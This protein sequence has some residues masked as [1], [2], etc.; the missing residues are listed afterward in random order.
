[1]KV[2]RIED[3]LDIAWAAR[4]KGYVFNPGFRGEA[5]LG[6]SSVS[7]Q[8]VKKMNEKYK[9]DGGFQVL[10]M[11]IAYYEGPDLIGYPYEYTDE[12]GNTRMGHALPHFWPTSGRGLIILEEPNRAKAMVR[13]CLMQLL[14]DRMVGP[15]YKLPDG[16]IVA[17]AWNNDAAHYD[18]EQ[19]DVA[20]E[21]RFEVFDIE[22][23]F[24]TFVYH[25]EKNNW[26]ENIQRYIKSGTWVYKTPDSIGVDGKYV[27]PRT[28]ERLNVA[29]KS[30]NWDDPAFQTMHRIICISKLGK[31]IGDDYWRSCWDD[32]PVVAADLI[33][34]P[35]KSLRKLEEQSSTGNTYA[36]D[37]IDQT[38][39]SIVENYDGYYQGRKAANGD[40]LPHIEGKIDEDMMAKVACIIPADLAANL[41]KG[42]GFQMN[43]QYK[44]KVTDFLQQFC[45][46]H[47]Q[48]IS[49]LKDNLKIERS[50]NR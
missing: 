14:T 25:I 41:I 1:M 23:D 16:W 32:A 21:D 18:V 29:E 24:N 26:S 13:N 20:L 19:M 28:F 49:I 38:I 34:N 10:D 47:P 30:A 7:Q 37:K 5:G 17:G 2:D 9:D 33:K 8:W 15:N 11:R 4:E 3:I 42:C 27:A 36:G 48:C 46:R 6:K 44:V 50:L 43:K 35:E 45:S 40:D 39:A 22:Y 12:N 31:H